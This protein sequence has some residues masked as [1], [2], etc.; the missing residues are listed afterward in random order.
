ML[1]VL[2][3]CFGGIFLAVIVFCL[4]WTLTELGDGYDEW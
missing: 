2:A 4:I 3:L 1:R